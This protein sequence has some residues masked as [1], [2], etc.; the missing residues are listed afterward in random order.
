MIF[1][2]FSDPGS[3][4]NRSPE[5]LERDPK[6]NTKKYCVWKASGS[7]LH[8]FWD[9]TWILGGSAKAVLDIFFRSWSCLGGKMAPGCPKSASKTDLGPIWSDFSKIFNGFLIDFFVDFGFENR[10]KKD[11]K[12]IKIDVKMPCLFDLI[13]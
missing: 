8:R 11:K 4:E 1:A 2:P 5:V 12:S 10:S 6:K 9:P 7:I 3:D 13:F